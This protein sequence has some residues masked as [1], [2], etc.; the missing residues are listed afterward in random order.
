YTFLDG[1]IGE[2]A[3]LF[4]DEYF[5]IGGDEVLDAEWRTNS[6]IQAFAK[7]HGLTGSAGLHAYFN[8]RIQA[9]PQKHGKRIIGW[10]EVNAPGLANDAV[11]QSW[12]GQKSLAEAA[13]KGYR[14]ILS[15]GYYLDHMKPAAFH[16]QVDPLGGD[17][18]QLNHQQAALILGGEA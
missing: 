3:A 6:G 7:L 12:R 13:E 1:F 16:Y 2:M 18:A 17:A 11:I 9:R 15:F 10:G 4:P 8:R 14:G 5:H